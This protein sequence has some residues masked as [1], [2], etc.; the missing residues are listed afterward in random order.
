MKDIEKVK[1][2]LMDSGKGSEIEKL[3]KS[4]EAAKLGKMIDTEALKKAASS[5]DQDALSSMLRQVLSTG[6]GQN[7]L[8]K[9]N[10]SFGEK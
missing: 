1:K 7:L 9:I 10:D 2:E 5:G 4:P 3:S 6:E 8:K